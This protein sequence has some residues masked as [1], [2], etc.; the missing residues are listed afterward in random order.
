MD[1]IFVGGIPS[2]TR[3]AS[4]VRLLTDLGYK[5][6]AVSCTISAYKEAYSKS[7]SKIINRGFCIIQVHDP[8]TYNLIL[9]EK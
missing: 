9:D 5:V 7:T 8:D 3:S 6:A 2:G 4:V 1:T